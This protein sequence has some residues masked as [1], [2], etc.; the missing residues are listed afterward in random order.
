MLALQTENSFPSKQSKTDRVRNHP[1]DWWR[2]CYYVIKSEKRNFICFQDDWW[3]RISIT[4]HYNSIHMIVNSQ[5]VINRRTPG[6]TPWKKTH[7]CHHHVVYHHA[8]LGSAALACCMNYTLVRLYA[9]AAWF[10]VKK[11]KRTEIK[12]YQIVNCY[13]SCSLY[14]GHWCAS[15]KKI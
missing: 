2:L 11:Q 1:V 13:W 7:R 3:V 9:G 5:H 8:S 6:D 4:T 15:F 10:S 14:F 12:F